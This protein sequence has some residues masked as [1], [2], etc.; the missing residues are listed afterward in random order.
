VRDRG[1]ARFDGGGLPA[2]AARELRGLLAAVVYALRVLSDRGDGGR[3]TGGTVEPQK[4]G[5]ADGTLAAFS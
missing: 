2:T 4:F 3:A 1:L 5:L